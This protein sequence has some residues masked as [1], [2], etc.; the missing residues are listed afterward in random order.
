MWG[1]GG[2]YR[3]NF[4]CYSD[5]FKFIFIAAGFRD[6]SVKTWNPETT[7]SQM[8]EKK[9]VPLSAK[10]LFQNPG[11]KFSFLFRC[12]LVDQ[13]QAPFTPTEVYLCMAF[14]SHRR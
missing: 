7:G 1:R 2:S 3:P 11:L 9:S 4:W 5:V 10:L 13:R 8:K 6:R 14:S 12:T